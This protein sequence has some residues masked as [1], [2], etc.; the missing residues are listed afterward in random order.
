MK[1]TRMYF[2]DIQTLYARLLDLRKQ[3]YKEKT[4]SSSDISLKLD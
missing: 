3:D 4:G 1:C 2:S